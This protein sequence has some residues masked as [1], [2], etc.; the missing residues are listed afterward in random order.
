MKDL[1]LIFTGLPASG[2][3]SLARSLATALDLD[4][5]DKDGS[6]EGLFDS[7]GC[8]NSD[9]RQRL[10]RESDRIL[11]ATVK[12]SQGAAVV[13]FWRGPS[14]PEN[15][16]TATDWISELPGNIMEIYCDCPPELAAKRFIQRERHPCHFDSKR[17]LEDMHDRF[18][19]LSKDGPLGLGKLVRVD[20]S[21]E[22]DVA[23]VARA[24]KTWV[25]TPLP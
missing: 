19:A 13:S 7:R 5:I 3:T 11:K 17:T 9:E 20:T 10:S 2:K 15:S 21:V 16:G 24:I 22:A 25:E 8:E 14:T 4:V 6:L 12:K 1:F 23:K 18:T